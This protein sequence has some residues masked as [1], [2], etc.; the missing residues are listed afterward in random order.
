M[1][2]VIASVRFASTA[3]KVG[4]SAKAASAV[5]ASS[6]QHDKRSSNRFSPRIQV[7]PSTW[8]SAYLR[9]SMREPE[10]YPLQQAEQF[11]RVGQKPIFRAVRMAGYTLVNY[12]TPA[13]MPGM[14]FKP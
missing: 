12:N 4:V 7:A 11:A 8:V 10:N 1:A 2:E 6:S 13:S 5:L 3:F 14:A 9:I